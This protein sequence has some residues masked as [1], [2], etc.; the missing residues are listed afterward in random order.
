MEKERKVEEPAG[1]YSAPAKPAQEPSLAA[2]DA[3][4]RYASETSFRSA[5]AKV[6][7]AHEELLKK[8]AQ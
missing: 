1:T 2:G 7:A 6:F 8:L 5:A 4:T 3:D